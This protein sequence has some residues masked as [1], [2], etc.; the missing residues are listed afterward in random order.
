MNGP[1]PLVLAVGQEGRLPEWAR[2][3]PGRLAHMERV[4]GLLET[5]GRKLDVSE[6]DLIRWR[7]AARLH[8]V[9][10]DADPEE[11]RPWAG[12]EWPDPLVHGA[13]CA[14]RLR[15]EGVDDE[16]LLLGIAYHSVGH[17]DF[18]DLG[19]L[20]Y[21]A[22]YLEPGRREGAERRERLRERLPAERSGVLREVAALRIEQLLDSGL[23]IMQA[24]WEFWNRL[25]SAGR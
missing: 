23:P 19:E 3:G 24:T 21:L 11:Q 4:A 20:L 15:Q 25:V 22:D 18:A 1:H 16:E 17:P 14:G 7:A 8:D 12:A 10:K 2:A 5:W 9:L 6:E 13:A